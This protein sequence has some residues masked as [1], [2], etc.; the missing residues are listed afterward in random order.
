M[1]L[2]FAILYVS[3]TIGLTRCYKMEDFFY[4][5]LINC[6]ILMQSFQS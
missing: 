2:I 3:R 5:Y 4:I 6:M 1:K